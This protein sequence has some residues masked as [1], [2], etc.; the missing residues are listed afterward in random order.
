MQNG[1]THVTTGEIDDTTN[2]SEVV[3][4][5]D[6]VGTVDYLLVGRSFRCKVFQFV[7]IKGDQFLL[8]PGNLVDCFGQPFPEGGLKIAMEA[9]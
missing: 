8:K 3:W 4:P 7:L 6:I 9:S 1:D 5:N 2:T